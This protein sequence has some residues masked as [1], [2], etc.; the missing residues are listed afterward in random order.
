MAV[1][2]VDDVAIQVR[3][4]PSRTDHRR[5]I[6]VA[7]ERLEPLI[8]ARLVRQKVRPSVASQT[9]V[10]LLAAVH[11]DA[12][13]VR[14]GL[15]GIAGDLGG[16]RRVRAEDHRD[17]AAG[18]LQFDVG[19]GDATHIASR[20]R[21]RHP[22]RW[23][24]LAVGGE[25]VER[26]VRLHGGIAEVEQR[27]RPVGEGGG[28]T[29]GPVGLE[30]AITVADRNPVPIWID[31]GQRGQDV[32]GGVRDQ[33]RVM[34]RQERP[35][36]LDEVEQIGYLLEVRRDVEVVAREV[37]VVE[38]EPDQ[39]LDAAVGRLQTTL[40]GRA[41]LTLGEGRHG[42]VGDQSAGQGQRDERR[43]GRK[44]GHETEQSSAH[45]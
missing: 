1:A 19:R 35:V 17:V 40:A 45:G 11:G 39:V 36:A 22:R 10:I 30:V 26:R 3:E 41:V 25:H 29:A 4:R 20:A 32:P 27:I 23:R 38:L 24:V 37:D 6:L 42:R 9:G 15:L 7:E 12:D 21:E 16:L 18:V 44:P 34:V 5:H 13:E 8:A 31:T 33:R 14:R 28:W 2:I 43:R